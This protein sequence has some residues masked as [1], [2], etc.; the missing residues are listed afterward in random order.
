MQQLLPT[1][2]LARTHPILDDATSKKKKPTKNE[3][4]DAK[5]IVG[6][7]GVPCVAIE[8]Q[9]HENIELHP[10]STQ[11][12]KS[13][14][15]NE[16]YLTFITQRAQQA[17]N[18]KEEFRVL[19]KTATYISNKKKTPELDKYNKRIEELSKEIIEQHTEYGQLELLTEH[20]L[21]KAEFYQ[22]LG[23]NR[24]ETSYLDKGLEEIA[25]AENIKAAGPE[26]YEL[27]GNIYL[28]K[29]E[30][31]NYKQEIPSLEQALKAHKKAVEI[32]KTNEYYL[33]NYL[34]T[35]NEYLAEAPI[36]KKIETIKEAHRIMDEAVAQNKNL[37]Q[38]RE[39]IGLDD[40]GDEEEL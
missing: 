29:A 31:G 35:L 13:R 4:E 8:D 28:N 7:Y 19:I 20:H 38:F 16:A 12:V 36:E 33:Q 39:Y 6:N 40:E 1:S 37:E 34:D 2:V 10:Q 14:T 30:I 22:E 32:E 18:A 26:E 9:I 5:R 11:W 17:N 3:I 21:I 24:G 27:K 25:K 15:F 23:I